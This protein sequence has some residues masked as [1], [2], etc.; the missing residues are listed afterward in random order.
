[1]AAMEYVLEVFH[2]PY[3]E[4]KPVICMDNLNAHTPCSL[5][6]T[7]AAAE[8]FEM[9]Q[10]LEIH[11]TPKHGSWLNIAE[12]ELKRHDLPMS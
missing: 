3:T 7:F 12:I 8:A 5:Y 2:R 11:Y 1:V 6:E 4:G 9:A 10:K